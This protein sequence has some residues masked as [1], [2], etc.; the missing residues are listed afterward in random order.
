MAEEVKKVTEN[1][2]QKE[3]ENQ[4][5]LFKQE[6]VNRIIAERLAREQE[7]YKDYEELKK[8]K[9]KL[10]ELENANKTE[11][12]KARAETDQ[13]KKLAEQKEV[14]KKQVLIENLKL[15]LLDQAGLPKSWAKRILGQTE[16][17]IKADIEELK[18]LLQEKAQ[19]VGLTVGGE[20]KGMPDFDK[21]SQAEYEEWRKKKK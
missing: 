17:E 13:F 15:S 14:E 11:L 12:E 7:K 3:G 16:D 1:P 19:N 6:E 21:M 2:T 10:D 5:K 9:T 8:A 4:E 18:K 20:P